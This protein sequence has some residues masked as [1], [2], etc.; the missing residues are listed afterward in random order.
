MRNDVLPTGWNKSAC[1]GLEGA[2]FEELFED[3]GLSGADASSD[4]DAAVSL[5]VLATQ[6]L[7]NNKG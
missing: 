7:H 4:D 5:W 3:G 2:L 6:L 1:A